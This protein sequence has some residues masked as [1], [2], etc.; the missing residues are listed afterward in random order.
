MGGYSLEEATEQV[1]ATAKKKK[2]KAST[3]KAVKPAAIKLSQRKPRSKGKP[4]VAKKKKS[5]AE[6]KTVLVVETSSS[7]DELDVSSHAL[8]IPRCMY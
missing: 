7:E 3:A 4:R 6:P 5:A 8:A 1:K 2:A